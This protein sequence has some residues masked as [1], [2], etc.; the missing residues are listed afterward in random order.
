MD[1]QPLNLST[2]TRTSPSKQNVPTEA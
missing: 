1:S 2:T